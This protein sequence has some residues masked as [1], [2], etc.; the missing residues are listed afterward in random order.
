M[1]V[2]GIALL[3]FH[4]VLGMPAE[5]GRGR[6]AN[7]GKARILAGGLGAGEGWESL[8]GSKCRQ[9]RGQV[10]HVSGFEVSGHQLCAQ[11]QG[12]DESDRYSRGQAAREHKEGTRPLK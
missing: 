9:V 2:H 7:E 6:T 8:P 3:P 12:T 5:Q 1:M 4:V 10:A 11:V